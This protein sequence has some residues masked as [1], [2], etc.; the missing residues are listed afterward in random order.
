MARVKFLLRRGRLAAW[1]L[2]YTRAMAETVGAVFVC[3]H[4]AGAHRDDCGM[5]APA[6]TLGDAGR[7]WPD[8]LAAA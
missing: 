8:G 7:R 5:L 3:A 6:Q 2:S 1:R 4:R